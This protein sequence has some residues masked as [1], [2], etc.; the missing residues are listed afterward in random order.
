MAGIHRVVMIAGSRTSVPTAR[1]SA[2]GMHL[3]YCVE[4][5]VSQ[6]SKKSK[7]GSFVCNVEKTQIPDKKK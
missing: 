7:H 4:P 6:D 2:F 5:A 1:N 3:V